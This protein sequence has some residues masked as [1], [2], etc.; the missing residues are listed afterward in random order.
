M[1]AERTLARSLDDENPRAAVAAHRNI[2]WPY[3]TSFA[4]ART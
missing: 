1:P 4:Q 3:P 2:I